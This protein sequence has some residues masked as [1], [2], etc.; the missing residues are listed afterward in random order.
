MNSVR[1]KIPAVPLLWLVRNS[2]GVKIRYIVLS[3]FQGR[4]GKPAC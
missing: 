1:N 3:A 4:G 2:K